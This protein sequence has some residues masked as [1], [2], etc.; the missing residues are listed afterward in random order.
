[1]FKTETDKK[2]EAVGKN[3]NGDSF[4]EKD[5]IEILELDKQRPKG[6]S[7]VKVVSFTFVA[8][9][10]VFVIGVIAFAIVKWSFLTVF[11]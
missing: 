1:M 8:L 5:F 9:G 10:I 7:F 4:S 11:K 2:I 6:E 3:R